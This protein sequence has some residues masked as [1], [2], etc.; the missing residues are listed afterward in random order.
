MATAEEILSTTYARFMKNWTFIQSLRQVAEVALPI[1]TKELLGQNAAL[2]EAMSKD[3]DYKKI[4]VM[5]DGSETE[6]SDAVKQIFRIGMTDLSIA[7]FTAAID[8]ASIVFAQSVLDDCA[9]S[10]LRV[11]ALAAPKDWDQFINERKVDFTTVREK[12]SDAIRE[13]LLNA[14]IEQMGQESLRKKIGMLFALCPPP[15]GFDPVGHYKFD[16]DRIDKIDNL[17]QSIIHH[18]GMGKQMT[19]VDGDLQYVLK[20]VH[21]LISLVHAKHGVKIDM[22]TM[23]PAAATAQASSGA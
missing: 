2:V 5:K 12:D 8:G 21:F 22:S 13:D 19:G 23:F 9:L 10:F 6:W 18:E 15:S 7:N 3:T 20:T 17:R 1:A 16:Q 4:V 11:C 14:K